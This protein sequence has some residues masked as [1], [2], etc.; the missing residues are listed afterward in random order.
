[1]HSN[2]T[3]SVIILNY[4]TFSLTCQCIESVIRYTKGVSYEI[5]MVDN[6]STECD[7]DEFKK[8]FPQITLIKNPVNSGFAKGNNLGISQASGI[9]LLLLNS[10][11]ELTEDSI[12]KCYEFL[13][14][15][16]KIGAISPKLVY[17]DG[18]TQYLAEQLPD[19][20]LE[21]LK[22]IRWHWF[23]SKKKA[24]KVFLSYFFDHNSDIEAGYV[25]A[26]FF[27]TR[28]E[29]VDKLPGRK[30]DDRHF[31]YA[32]ELFWCYAIRKQGYT[33][34][35]YAGTQAIHYHSFSFRKEQKNVKTAKLAL[36][37]RNRHE[38]LYMTKGKVYTL[39]F[40]FL[41]I[42]YSLSILNFTRLRL[43]FSIMFS[44]VSSGIK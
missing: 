28:K 41:E 30:L 36:G 24:E 14:K 44:K 9:Y 2:P 7:A 33:I 23:L 29:I 22:L 4:N 20:R 12:N 37:I 31:M 27:M 35:Y 43:I 6:A 13:E 25:W 17:P 26:A 8:L 16:R 18:T 21:W 19:I 39:F 40:Y 15:N 38:F 5:I 32:E 3:V 10:D 34:W 11:I 42:L 1:M